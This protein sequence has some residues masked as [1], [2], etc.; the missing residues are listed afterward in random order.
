ML[1]ACTPVGGCPSACCIAHRRRHEIED[2]PAVVVESGV[3]FNAETF[4]LDLTVPASGALIT[5]YLTT[6]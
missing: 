3:R 1:I 6:A 5:G 2:E 4:Q